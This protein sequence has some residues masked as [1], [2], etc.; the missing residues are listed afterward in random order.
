MKTAQKL[1]LLTLAFV[2]ASCNEKVSPELQSSSATTPTSPSTPIAPTDYYFSVTDASPSMLNYKLHK[3]GA[4]N[5][6]D[7]C[8]VKNQTGLS[9][10]DFASGVSNDI[11]CFFEAE[12]LSLYHQ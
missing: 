7:K 6:S 3:T 9:N 1:S 2:V 12:E 8:E 11:S 4:R 10:L 5:S